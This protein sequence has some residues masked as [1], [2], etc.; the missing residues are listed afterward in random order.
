MASLFLQF[1]ALVTTTWV[2]QGNLL[3]SIIPSLSSL[4]TS[5]LMNLKSSLL[6]RRDL[7]AIGWMV[8]VRLGKGSGGS[9]LL[10][11]LKPQT[12]SGGWVP[13]YWKATPSIRLV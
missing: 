1:S 11:V 4:S 7:V 5:S 8:S 9:I 10:R 12:D 6:Y 2:L 13:L 3:D